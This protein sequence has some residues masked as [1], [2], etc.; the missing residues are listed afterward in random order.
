MKLIKQKNETWEW[1]K[2]L[3]I[4]F[5]IAFLIRFFLFTPVMVD[6]KSMDPTLHDKE[7]MMVNKFSYKIGEPQR[8]D[9][10][11]FHATEEKDYIK[12]VIALPGEHIAYKNDELYINGKIM[13][14]PYL[15]ARKKELFKGE[16]TLTEDFTLEDTIGETKIP[17][18]YVFVMGDNR[19]NSLDSRII[20]LVPIE[21]IVGKTNVI[22][23]PLDKFRYTK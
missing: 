21:E 13:D 12:R 18:G 4:A 23:W 3:L 19:R 15:E 6:G 9:L 5:T 1:I 20:G 22:Y 17:E 14:E 11:V 10:V 16:G 7:R 8:Y 2:A